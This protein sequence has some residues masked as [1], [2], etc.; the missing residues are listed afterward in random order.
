LEDHVEKKKSSFKIIGLVVLL[1]TALGVLLAFLDV[2]LSFM[3]SIGFLDIPV[4]LLLFYVGVFLV[5]N[6]HEL[7]HLI[8]GKLLG[9]QFLMFRA[10][11]FSIH[12][13]NGKL[14]F[15]I[16]R[17]VGYGGLCAMIPS[18][19]SD[20]R[21]FA[22]Y[23]TGGIIFNLITGI[24][25]LFLPEI[26]S[27]N[28]LLSVPL[29]GTGMV[30]ILLALINAWP[31]F[32]MNQPTDGM[33]F[34]SILK[35]NPLAERFYESVILSKKLMTGVRPRDLDLKEPK[36]PLLDQHETSNVLYLYFM[37]L[38]GGNIELA[39]KY[40]HI[41]EEN[42]SKVPPYALPAFY[43][44]IIF[45]S[46]LTGDNE[47][48]VRYYEKAGKILVKDKDINGMRIKAYYAYYVENDN[49]KALSLA[50]EGVSVMDKY[51]FRG[52]AVF[53]EDQL[54]KLIRV[55]EITGE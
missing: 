31:F 49:K 45:F 22:F 7:G 52:Q 30:S 15:S 37:A 27:V 33:M 29:Y 44:E 4:V 1:G 36:L 6:I 40:I 5:I 13:E 39:R 51:P 12:K 25:F 3:D 41:I 20:L 38:D 11:I 35:K 26:L 53:E 34:I 16:I 10:G 32:S 17:N 18:E 46:L 23:S 54:Q 50:E 28:T 43:Y 42:L 21:D 19:D 48:A 47:K 55:I 8:F 24:L 9:Y 14:R 2:D